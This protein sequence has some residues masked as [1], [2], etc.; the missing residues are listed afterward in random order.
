MCRIVHSPLSIVHGLKFTDHRPRSTVHSFKSIVHSL[1]FIVFLNQS[2]RCLWTVV[3][4]LFRI[5]H[6]SSR[7]KLVRGLWSVDCEPLRPIHRV[8]S[9]VKGSSR[10]I[11]ICR[12]LTVV[13]GLL[14]TTSTVA[15]YAGYKPVADLTAFKKQFALE[16][17]KTQSIKSSFEQE[18]NLAVLEEKIVSHGKFYFKRENKVR[19]E[20]QTPFQYL[21]IMN[22]DQIITRDKQKENKV[23]VKSNKLF[24]QVN[25]IMIDCVQ[26]SVVDSKDFTVRVFENDKVWLL[27][28]SPVSKSLKDFFKTIVVHADK[29]DYSVVSIDMQE[30]SGDNTLIKFVQKE[31]NVAVSD[32]LF[33][34]K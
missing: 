23:S 18:K 8:C 21:L 27:E 13:C 25:K 7:Q 2:S 9:V 14:F 33:N 26:G 24:Q 10:Q 19:I 20:Y 15:Q 34:V 31:L 3:C 32:E 1:W 28:M 30:P 29:K 17:K 22:G 6:S 4:G 5:V 12:L 16:A 11:L